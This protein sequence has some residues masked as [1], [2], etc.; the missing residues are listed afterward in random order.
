M[1]DSLRFEGLTFPE[2]GSVIS[3]LEVAIGPT[4]KLALFGPNGAG[5]TTMLR[6]IA[7]ADRGGHRRVD[8]AY[9]PQRPYMFRGTV[10][11]NLTLGGRERAR[12][13]AVARELGVGDLLDRD[14]RTLSGGI[15]QRVAL[16]RVLAGDESLVLLDEPLGPIDATDRAAVVDVILA[17]TRDRAAIAVT[18]SVDAA[19]NL[20]DTLAVV[21][22]GIILQRG[23][24]AEVLGH[25]ASKRVAEIVGEGNVLAGTIVAS[26]GSVGRVSVGDVELTAVTERAV[27]DRVLIRIAPETI[28]VFDAAPSGVSNRNIIEATVAEIR[29]TGTLFEVVAVEPIELRAVITPGALDDMSIAQGERVWFGVKASAIGIVATR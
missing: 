22:G 15:A 4:E 27:G 14:A 29:Q 19:V 21:D 23:P 10:G 12:V 18:H 2:D 17:N 13:V 1:G 16:A 8:V 25:P 24:V 3:D 26:T 11:H 9:L 6:A 5:K 7:G 28:T 20:A